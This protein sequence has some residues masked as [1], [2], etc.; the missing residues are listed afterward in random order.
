MSLYGSFSF[1]LGSSME[2]H[3]N[4][5]PEK[6]P[7]IITHILKKNSIT[8]ERPGRSRAQLM[9]SVTTATPVQR[10]KGPGPDAQHQSWP[11]NPVLTLTWDQTKTILY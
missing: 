6:P 3:C 1:R 9:D 11:G 4:K 5:Q 7:E 2:R 8:G 10:P